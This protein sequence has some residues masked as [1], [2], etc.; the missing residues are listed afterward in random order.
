V[1]AAG[2][3]AAHPATGTRMFNEYAWGGYLA[4]RF[5]PQPDRRVYILSEGVLMGDAQLRR[6]HEVIALGPRW[7]RIL[8]EDRVDY[9]VFDRGAALDDVLAGEPGWR[10]A[11]RDQTAVVYVRSPG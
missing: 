3:L 11:Y 4:D 10:L 5:F 1:G 2:W 8:D 7:R 6:Y 9:V